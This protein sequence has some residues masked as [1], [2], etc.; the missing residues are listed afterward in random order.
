[1]KSIFRYITLGWLMLVAV[2]CSDNKERT[3]EFLGSLD[4]TKPAFAAFTQSFKCAA[5]SAGSLVMALNLC[6]YITAP[7]ENKWM[8]EDMYY[9]N[10]K[11]RELEEGRWTVFNDHWVEIYNNISDSELDQTGATWSVESNPRFF[12]GNYPDNNLAIKNIG[13]DTFELDFEKAELFLNH[14]NDHIFNYVTNKYGQVD[15]TTTSCN[16]AVATNNTAFRNGDAPEL[17]IS[18]SGNGMLSEPDRNYRVEY[19]IT[20]PLRFV[21]DTNGYPTGP[22]S[23]A[24]EI[25]VLSEGRIDQVTALM[26]PYNT[27]KLTYEAYDTTLTGYYSWDGSCITPR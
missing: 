7:E 12:G 6:E 22:C 9:S 15:T 2:G 4:A 5:N 26:S 25:M 11:I 8:V 19:R 24:M 20:D 23:G 17:M 16:L 3:E 14:Y 27:I 13:G 18:I 1:M 21:Y 10:L